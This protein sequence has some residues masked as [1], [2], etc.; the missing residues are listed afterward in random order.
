MSNHPLQRVADLEARVTAL[1]AENEALRARINGHG[2][3]NGLLDADKLVEA[4]TL[5]IERSGQLLRE[6][7]TGKLA[8]LIAPYI[9][10]TLRQCEEVAAKQDDLEKRFREYKKSVAGSAAELEASFV[11]LRKEA[12]KDWKAQRDI[13][14]ED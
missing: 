11:K 10:K 5:R 12:N 14:Q 13:I 4:I 8:A 6:D 3:G 1:T 2:N 9:D 7:F